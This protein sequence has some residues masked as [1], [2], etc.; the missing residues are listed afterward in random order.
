MAGYGSGDAVGAV[1]AG[2]PPEMREVSAYALLAGK[3][4][5]KLIAS[6]SE[7]SGPRGIRAGRGQVAG[8]TRMSAMKVSLEEFA[9]ALSGM[10][11]VLFRT[12]LVWPE[13]SISHWNLQ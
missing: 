11:G 5:A 2:D 12:G 6:G 8:T 9:A 1:Q 13:T 4:G 10:L 7:D 3:G